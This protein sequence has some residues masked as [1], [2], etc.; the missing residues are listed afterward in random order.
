MKLSLRPAD[1]LLAWAAP[2]IAVMGGAGFP[3][4]ATAMAVERDDGSIAGVVAF[5]DWQ[6]LYKT[7][8][9]SAV[10]ESAH[11]MRARE[12]WRL[13]FRY[14]FDY[15]GAEKLWSATPRQNKRALRF[16]IGLG[17]QPEAVLERHFGSD[18]A[19]ISRL[20]AHEWSARLV[21]TETASRARSGA[22]H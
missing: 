19:V 17:F 12:A 4:D 11:W 6:P 16:V 1:E 2:R 22:A 3:A 21:E 5:H 13:M 7:L 20:F 15:V 10:S 18:D 14:A 9:V 8:Q